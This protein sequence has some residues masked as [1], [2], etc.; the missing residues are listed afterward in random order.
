V[1]CDV[2][3]VQPDHQRQVRAGQCLAVGLAG[4]DETGL[5]LA[6]LVLEALGDGLGVEADRGGMQPAAQGQQL[7]E[8]VGRGAV[9]GQGDELG[10]QVQHFRG[11]PLQQRPGQRAEQ[12]SRSR[13]VTTSI[14]PP[15]RAL[16]ASRRPGRSVRDVPVRLSV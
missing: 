12:A 5:L 3:A 11:G 8:Q 13:R 9:G 4:V 15:R 14:S 7:A 10:L 1:N 6:D 16:M 2:A